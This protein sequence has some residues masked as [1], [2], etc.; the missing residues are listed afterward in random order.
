VV[1]GALAG[2]F[3]EKIGLLFGE[4]S[5]DSLFASAPNKIRE[6]ACTHYSYSSHS[7]YP[8]QTSDDLI[9]SHHFQ[10]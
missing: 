4:H 1:F 2:N 3:V 9:R 6:G 8:S 10:L 5:L 7:S